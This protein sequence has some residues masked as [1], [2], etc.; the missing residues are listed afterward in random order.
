MHILVAC[1]LLLCPPPLQLHSSRP[2]AALQPAWL[3]WLHIHPS[4]IL[5][6]T[7]P[8]SLPPPAPL[9]PASQDST[10]L[11]PLIF[12][13]SPGSD[14]MSALLKYAD[15][16]R[17]SCQAISLGQ[18]QGPKAAKLIEEARANGGWVV[19]QVR[20]KSAGGAT[21]LGLLAWP[22]GVV[23]HGA[24][25]GTWSC[26]RQCFKARPAASCLKRC[27]CT[28]AHSLRSCHSLRP[29]LLPLP[30]FP[31]P[32]TTTTTVC[33][34][35]ATWRSAGCPPWSGCARACPWTTPTPP[36]GCGSPPTPARHSLS[37]C[38]RWARGAGQGRAREAALLARWCL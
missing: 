37:A 1:P 26:V 33:T 18:G 23:A 9:F 13:L 7:L 11:T 15:G 6:P 19:L 31:P 35:T 30:I 12:V 29:S 32:P 17:L 20:R 34:R 25:A 4:P 14:P 8:P 24:E 10:C 28:Y 27:S 22:A 36:S 16:L 2:P 38:C 5:C 21:L 3:A